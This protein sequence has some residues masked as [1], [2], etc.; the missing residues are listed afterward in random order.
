MIPVG[1][2]FQRNA[3]AELVKGDACLRTKT[4]ENHLP[5]HQIGFVFL[6][7]FPELDGEV[8]AP[9]G[10]AEKAGDVVN[11]VNVVFV[12]V[13]VAGKEKPFPFNGFAFNSE[14]EGRI[15]R[16]NND[17]HIL[18]IEMRL[19]QAVCKSFHPVLGKVPVDA[20]DDCTF[21]L[22]RHFVW[23][24]FRLRDDELL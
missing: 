23:F 9:A 13:E 5:R 6:A 1:S 16:V 11:L 21:K 3:F 19:F 17:V 24:M 8:S 18:G 20:G 2:A 7:R 15:E 14:V 22:I 4:C 12:L 10:I